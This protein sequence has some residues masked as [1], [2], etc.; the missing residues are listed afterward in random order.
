MPRAENGPTPRR[1]WQ[2][3]QYPSRQVKA[4]KREYASDRKR[5][6]RAR[7]AVPVVCRV[8]SV[9][10]LASRIA[11]AEAVPR[12]RGLGRGGA[13][14]LAAGRSWPGGR[15]TRDSTKNELRTCRRSAARKLPAKRHL[16]I[17]Y[18]YIRHIV[19]SY[20]RDM[21][22]APGLTHRASSGMSRPPLL[23]SMTSG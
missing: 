6:R 4:D 18:R 17:T 20:A 13:P 14:R 5:P 9:V 23:N 21:Y 3:C 7:S 15:V 12:P 2:D 19:L 10:R 8:R 11:R 16:G 1:K 22:T